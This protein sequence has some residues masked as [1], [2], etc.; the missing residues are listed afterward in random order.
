MGQPI[1]YY[2]HCSKYRAYRLNGLIIC[3]GRSGLSNGLLGLG[4]EG[5]P[6]VRQLTATCALKCS[7]LLLMMMMWHHYYHS[8]SGRYHSATNVGPGHRSH[9]LANTRAARRSTISSVWPHGRSKLDKIIFVIHLFLLRRWF[10]GDTEDFLKIANSENV[11]ISAT[12]RR[13]CNM[14]QTDDLECL[15]LKEIYV[16]HT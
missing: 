16:F 12:A 4:K 2:S 14:S 7:L 1:T 9:N 8:C 13:Q 6:G 3:S 5:G 15:S 10:D 11:K